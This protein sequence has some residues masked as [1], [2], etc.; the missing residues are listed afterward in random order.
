M[1]RSGPG[2]PKFPRPV[3]AVILRQTYT[4]VSRISDL[5][6]VS[7]CTHK[8]DL[9]PGPLSV[10]LPQGIQGMVRTMKTMLMTMM[11]MMEPLLMERVIRVLTVGVF[12]GSCA[13]CITLVVLRPARLAS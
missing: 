3:S 10:A 2:Q 6:C 4:A 1:A 8:Q 12:T 13:S 11:T 9:R 5:W 7:R